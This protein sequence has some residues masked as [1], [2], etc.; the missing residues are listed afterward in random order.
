M[1]K[2]FSFFWLNYTK[3]LNSID[4]KGSVRHRRGGNVSQRKTA[5]LLSWNMSKKANAPKTKRKTSSQCSW[6]FESCTIQTEVQQG[7]EN[8]QGFFV[9]R[10]LVYSVSSAPF[11][12]HISAV[13]RAGVTTITGI[14]SMWDRSQ[15][16]PSEDTVC[17]Y[18]KCCV[19]D[20]MSMS[21]IIWRLLSF[22]VWDVVLLVFSHRGL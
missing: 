4:Q 6:S 9:H 14:T 19:W 2:R 3:H 12:I 5:G 22:L 18:V 21:P 11:I 16:L 7:L 13:Y 8:L 20:S 17:V 1:R 10:L 15:A